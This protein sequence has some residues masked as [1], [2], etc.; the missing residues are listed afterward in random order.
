MILLVWQ[1]RETESKADS[2][3]EIGTKGVKR[4]LKR[5]W[6]CRKLHLN[7]SRRT[8]LS[9][10]FA[11]DQFPSFQVSH[12]CFA[13]NRRQVIRERVATPSEL[14]WRTNQGRAGAICRL[15]GLLMGLNL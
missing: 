15:A 3:V 7:R 2:A 1:R 8:K 12:R 4:N 9:V 11:R 13:S 5:A 6:M 10:L 14:A